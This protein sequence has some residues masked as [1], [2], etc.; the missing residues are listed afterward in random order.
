[1]NYYYDNQ[2]YKYD[3]FDH[4]NYYNNLLRII[5]NILE[6]NPEDR[7]PTPY[8]MILSKINQLENVHGLNRNKLN[9][10]KG[11]TEIPLN[12]PICIYRLAECCYNQNCGMCI[13]LCIYLT[14]DQ[15][16]LWEQ[17]GKSKIKLFNISSTEDQISLWKQQKKSKIDAFTMSKINMVCKPRKKLLVS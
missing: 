15:I 16:S 11:N 9:I 13:E 14:D 10:F 6:K 4:C 17:Q 7:T 12:F 8:F 5:Y 1:M 3:Q 2:Y